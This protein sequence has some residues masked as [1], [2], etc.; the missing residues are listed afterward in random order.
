MIKVG[1][2]YYT[3]RMMFCGRSFYLFFRMSWPKFSFT[4]GICG[5]DLIFGWFGLMTLSDEFKMR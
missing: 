3:R 1:C 2:N 5:V 4:R